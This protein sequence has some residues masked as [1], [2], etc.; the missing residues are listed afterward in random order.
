MIG[1]SCKVSASVADS[2]VGKS[3]VG[4]SVASTVAGSGVR[5][6][7]ICAL[8]GKQPLRRI[9]SANRLNRSVP[10]RNVMTL[11]CRIIAE[12]QYGGLRIF[13]V[14]HHKIMASFGH[15]ALDGC[16]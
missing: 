2:S 15:L 7:G 8:A 11:F 4:A 9:T 12:L 6:G 1:A 3:S 16:P 13:E 14:F 5:V 10:V